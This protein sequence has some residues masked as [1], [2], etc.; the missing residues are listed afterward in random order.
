MSQNVT[1]A[2]VPGFFR[3]DDPTADPN[4]IG[5]VSKMWPLGCGRGQAEARSSLVVARPIRFARFESWALGEVQAQ[6][7]GFGLERRTQGFD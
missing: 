3:Q 2:Y 4:V 7:Q 1:Y 6:D 5:A